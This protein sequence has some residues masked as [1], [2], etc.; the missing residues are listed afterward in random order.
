MLISLQI[1]LSRNKLSSERVLVI[2]LCLISQI[3][4]KLI[5]AVFNIAETQLLQTSE[6]K[7]FKPKQLGIACLILRHIQSVSQFTCFLFWN[8][9]ELM[10][11]AVL[12]YHCPIV[13]HLALIPFFLYSFELG[14]KFSVLLSNLSIECGKPLIIHKPAFCLFASLAQQISSFLS[15]AIDFSS[16]FSLFV[17][18]TCLISYCCSFLNIFRKL[19]ILIKVFVRYSVKKIQ[20]A[21]L[22][23]AVTFCRLYHLTKLGLLLCQNIL[24]YLSHVGIVINVSHRHFSEQQFFTFCPT[25]HICLYCIPQ[26]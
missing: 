10:V 15:Q 8:K 3:R 20:T 23:R 4:I 12:Q 22:Q 5:T 24:E 11:V 16:Q 18:I 21:L 9:Y 7:T 14:I 6:R 17:L 19:K 13:Y 25:L 1:E 2:E 26:Y